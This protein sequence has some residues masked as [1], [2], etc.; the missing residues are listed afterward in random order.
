MDQADPHGGG[1]VVSVTLTQPR[2]FRPVNEQAFR[3]RGPHEC[4]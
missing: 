1:D 3:R 2:E 4:E